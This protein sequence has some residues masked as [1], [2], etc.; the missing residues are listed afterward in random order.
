MYL[1]LNEKPKDRIAV[2]EDTG[3][4]YSYGEL[5]DFVEEFGGWLPE[6]SLIFILCRNTMATM[7]G[8]VAAI[9]NQIVPLMISCKMDVSL[10]NTL[11]ETYQPE[12]LW[13]PRELQK[14]F[15]YETIAEKYDYLLIRTGYDKAPLYPELSMLLTTSGSTGSPKLV[16]H[17]YKNLFANAENVASFFGFTDRDRPLIDLQLHYTMG[18]NVAC[19]SLFAGATLVM[20]TKTAMEREYWQVFKERHVTNITGVPY[21][22]ELL[23]KLR[24]F[25]MDLPDLRILA[26]GGGK[27]SDEMFRELAEYAERTGKKFFATFGTT[28]TTARLAYLEPDKALEHIGSIGK[29]IPKGEL[30]LAD[31][32]GNV[33]QTAEADG[34]LVYRG[35]NVTLGYAQK[36]EDLSLGDERKGV[37]YTGDLAHRDSEGFYYI[38]GR[39]SRFLKLYGYRVGLD[40][41]E[42]LIRDAF[43]VECACVGNDTQM[44]IYVTKENKEQEIRR[45]I[46]DKTKIA[47]SA[48]E[49]IVVKELPKNE[50]GK[51]LYRELRRD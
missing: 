42:R 5:C 34:E 45:F 29:A 31:E 3:E 43:Q 47:I 49:V 40:E 7:A 10:R 39:K 19:S 1:R 16:R 13:I 24:F 46:S 28:E 38:I 12:Y 37:Y 25:K 50:V 11:I 2:L 22:Y 30:F 41:S 21:N 48:F 15:P 4:Q 14:E 18:L 51:I 20:T 6:R 23:K 17:S 9:E 32:E 26:Q 36:R 27:L 35:D 33:I 44:E 8:H